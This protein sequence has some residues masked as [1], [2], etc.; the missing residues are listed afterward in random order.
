MRQTVQNSERPLLAAAG[1][2]TQQNVLKMIKYCVLMF[3]PGVY[4]DFIAPLLTGVNPAILKSVSCD[5]RWQGEYFEQV[6]F[7]RLGV[8]L[9]RTRTEPH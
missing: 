6:T 4:P 2:N 8:S 1:V 5:T 3:H 9:Q 7:Q